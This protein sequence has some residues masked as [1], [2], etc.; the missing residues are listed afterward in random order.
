MP[1]TDE[2]V[3]PGPGPESMLFWRLA[4]GPASRPS[5]ERG[6]RASIIVSAVTAILVGFGGAR[7]PAMAEPKE[8]FA[9]AVDGRPK[10]RSTSPTSA[11]GSPTSR[12][13]RG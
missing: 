5:L 10:P 4:T 9:S 11:C 6:M 12:A 13:G 1:Y 7:A 8:R 2:P 3:G